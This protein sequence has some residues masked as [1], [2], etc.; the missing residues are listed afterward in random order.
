MQGR[1]IAKLSSFTPISYDLYD[2]ALSLCFAFQKDVDSLCNA[3]K[4]HLKEIVSQDFEVNTQK[5]VT[6]I[7]CKSLEK[8]VL[9]REDLKIQCRA[10]VKVIS[11]K[12]TAG[13]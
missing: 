9:L 2:H 5:L 13:N 11:L 12:I 4:H 1:E 10:L 8:L 7:S 6:D 3:Y